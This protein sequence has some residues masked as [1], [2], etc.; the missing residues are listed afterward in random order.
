M[1]AERTDLDVPEGTVEPTGG[2]TD[3][4][5]PIELGPGDG[6]AHPGE[7]SGPGTAQGAGFVPSLDPDRDD[8]ERN[9]AAGGWEG[10]NEQVENDFESEQLRRAQAGT[11]AE[12]DAAGEAGTGDED[13]TPLT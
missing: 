7:G 8:E 2:V 4:E 5:T 13:A 9:A 10:A 11:D 3:G 12:A 6:V 1:N